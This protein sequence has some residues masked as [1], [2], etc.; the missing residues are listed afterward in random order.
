MKNIVLLCL[1]FIPVCCY[2]QTSYPL[3][4]TG[5]SNG[6]L[7][8]YNLNSLLNSAQMLI[9]WN[10]QPG[11][12]E[13]SF[14]T[15]QGAGG[16]G[17]FAFYNYDNNGSQTILMRLSGNG[18]T[19]LFGNIGVGN[20]I[21]T[22][23]LDVSGNILL[24]NYQNSV[25]GGSTLQFS[26]YGAN[27]EHPGARIRDYLDYASGADS[28]S[29]LILSSYYGGYKDEL[30]L[31]NGKIGINKINPAYELDVNGQIHTKGILV[32]TTGF[33]EFVFNK[34]YKLKSLKEVESFIIQNYHLPELPS[35]RQ[36]IKQGIDLA[37]MNK[38]LLQKVE[39]LTLYIIE[40][41]R[42][43]RDQELRLK[44]IEKILNR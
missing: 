11:L 29:R 35:Q 20:V 8:G 13:A 12:G 23:P 17:G 2:S 32:N 33:P 43:I 28:Q 44:R 5:G 3:L 27:N 22:T 21:P 6:N 25:G 18:N 15:N 10:R 40:K 19:T 1:I 37:E 30:T 39:E 36:A 41:D 14:I 42:Q 7:D 26:S 4:L 16:P 24:R 34:N 31:V 9:G 38:K